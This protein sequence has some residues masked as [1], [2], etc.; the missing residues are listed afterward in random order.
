MS[1]NIALHTATAPSVILNLLENK[2][3]ISAELAHNLVLALYALALPISSL[4]PSLSVGIDKYE[5][6]YENEN[7]DEIWRRNPHL[8]Y[9]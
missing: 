1:L 2:E 8:S 3:K 7:N 4:T 9:A 6:D 5:N